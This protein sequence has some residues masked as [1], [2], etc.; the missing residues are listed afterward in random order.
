MFK[1]LSFLLVSIFIF[2]LL[3]HHFILASQEC[4]AGS[5]PDGTCIAN[6]DTIPIGANADG[7]PR[8]AIKECKN[9]Y[10]QCN[11]FFNQGECQKN[12][13]WMIM[14][15]PVS[16]NAC[17]LRDY[18]ARCQRK[19]LNVSDSPI[20]KP[21]DMNAMFSA[22]E[23]E[24]KG[25]YGNIEVLSRVYVLNYFSIFQFFNSIFLGPLGCNN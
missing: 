8:E 3:D 10:D 2:V 13:G 4:Q 15:C 16:C 7:R 22:I 20:Y 17:H 23:T 18:N 11:Q 6:F 5:N 24:F 19:F 14:N 25:K 9:R 12:P 21:G 1:I